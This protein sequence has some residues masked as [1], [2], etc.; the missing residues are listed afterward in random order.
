MLKKEEQKKK[1]GLKDKL[2]NAVENISVDIFGY[3]KK[4]TK[5]VVQYLNKTAIEQRIPSD[6]IFARIIKQDVT[7]RVFIHH[8]GMQ[9][10]E[11]PVKELATFFAGEGTT[12]LFDIENKVAQSVG[13]YIDELSK[14]HEVRDDNLHVRI[15][16]SDF[17]VIVS[18]YNHLQFIKFIPVKDLVKYFKG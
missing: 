9:L 11:V 10:K 16:T 14:E 13:K 15:S 12:E 4:I 7:V 17:K 5:N 3:E 2:K 8:R 6:Q 18:A 1:L